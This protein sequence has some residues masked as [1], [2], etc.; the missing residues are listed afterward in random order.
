MTCHRTRGYAHLR[1]HRLAQH[2]P[3]GSQHHGYRLHG[4]W[5]GASRS[6]NS[7]L[8]RGVLP[9]QSPYRT[10]RQMPSQHRSGYPLHAPKGAVKLTLTVSS[11][12]GLHIPPKGR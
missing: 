3:R 1:S 7:Q 6:G 11:S 9:P 10:P 12:L 2:H 8:S 5:Y 4:H